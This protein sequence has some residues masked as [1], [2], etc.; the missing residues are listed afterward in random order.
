MRSRSIALSLALVLTLSG[1]VPLIAGPR[2]R[3]EPRWMD[4]IDRIIRVVKKIFTAGTNGDGLMPPN[5]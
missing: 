4:P 5:P 3:D 1:A 2:S